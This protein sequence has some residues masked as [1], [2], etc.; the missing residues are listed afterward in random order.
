MKQELDASGVAGKW[1]RKGRMKMSEPGSEVELPLEMGQA[2]QAL[3]E[4]AARLLAVPSVVLLR[5]VAGGM[6]V[7]AS[8]GTDHTLR[9]GKKIPVAEK[10]A[11]GSEGQAAPWRCTLAEDDLQATHGEEVHW[12]DG[13]FFGALCVFDS[14]RRRYPRQHLQ[15]LK[16]LRNLFEEELRLAFPCMDTGHAFDGFFSRRS[17][18]V[19]IAAKFRE[20]WAFLETIVNNTADLICLKDGEGRWLLANRAM[21]DFFSSRRA[22]VPGPDEPRSGCPQQLLSVCF[23]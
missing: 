6:E 22:G 13:S 15:L 21:L 7:I 10:T 8:G 17:S 14:A 23:P 19:E 1:T 12:P 5:T 9:S 16:R 3:L 11:F 4:T 18:M 20:Q 2:W